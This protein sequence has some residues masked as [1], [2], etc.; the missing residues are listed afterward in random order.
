ML[1]AGTGRALNDCVLCLFPQAAALFRRAGGVGVNVLGS[2]RFG[3]LGGVGAQRPGV[4]ASRTNGTGHRPAWCAQ[5]AT[6]LQLFCAV[7]EYMPEHALI[8]NIKPDTPLHDLPSRALLYLKKAPA[9][10]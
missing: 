10:Y 6:G 4:C 7:D 9:P 8:C 3:H 1:T 2:Y 5:M